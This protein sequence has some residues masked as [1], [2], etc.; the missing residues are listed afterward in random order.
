MV[1]SSISSVF[2][3]FFT[4]FAINVC[5]QKYKQATDV[6]GVGK[7]EATYLVPVCVFVCV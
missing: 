6:N 1:G 2:I 7:V 5:V 3:F 4:C